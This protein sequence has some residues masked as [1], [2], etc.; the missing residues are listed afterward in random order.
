MASSNSKSDGGSGAPAVHRFC[1]AEDITEGVAQS[2][3]MADLPVAVCRLD[4][5]LAA[6]SAL[7][8]H[9]RTDLSEGIVGRGGIT[10]GDHLWHF[11]LRDGRCAMV[12]GARLTIYP[13]REEDGWILVELPT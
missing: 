4:G 1:P 11:D 8:P 3:V 13:V 7:C 2:R 5:K 10:C 9:L 12:P 6:F